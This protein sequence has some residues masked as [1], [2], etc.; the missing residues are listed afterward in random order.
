MAHPAGCNLALNPTFE[1]G[2][3]AAADSWLLAKT[4]GSGTSAIVSNPVQS[5]SRAVQVAVTQPGDLYFTTVPERTAIAVSPNRSYLFSV[6][7]LSSGGA[8]AAIR[9]IEWTAGGAVAAD[10]FLATGGGTGSWVTLQGSF[11]S[12]ANTSFVSLRLNHHISTGTFTW[13]DARFWAQTAGERCVDTRHYITQSTSGFRM[14]KSDNS[15]C[16]DGWQDNYNEFIIGYQRVGVAGDGGRDYILHNGTSATAIGI[17][18]NYDFDTNQWRCFANPG[19]ACG[20]P[21]SG[22]NANYPPQFVMIAMSLPLLSNAIP[23]NTRTPGAFLVAD[24]QKFD[25]RELNPNDGSQPRLLGSSWSRSLA[26]V[27][28]SVSFEGTLGTRENVLVIEQESIRGEIT[29]TNLTGGERLERYFYVEGYGR[30]REQG[31]EDTDCR[32]TP[33]ATTCNGNYN[34]FQSDSIFNTSQSGNYN[35]NSIAPYNIVNWW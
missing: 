33:N 6:R 11:T 32:S 16:L 8:L 35:V 3:G 29:P 15:I 26:F 31:M 13:D 20:A 4:S 9:V 1:H 12:S 22:A 34:F 24:W 25:V 17:H 10:S 14:C 27:A 19:T 30:V 2:T 5:G 28:S 18:K 7:L 23:N 21:A